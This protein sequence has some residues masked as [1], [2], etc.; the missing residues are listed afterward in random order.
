[1]IYL[2]NL[3]SC[4]AFFPNVCCCLFCQENK[5]VETVRV[6]MGNFRAVSLCKTSLRG[7]TAA[8]WS[9]WP[10]REKSVRGLL[11]FRLKSAEVWVQGEEKNPSSHNCKSGPPKFRHILLKGC[12]FR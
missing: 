4:S 1:M 5:T 6:N 10:H 9:L 3:V 7:T 11:C 12:Y 8:S 2:D